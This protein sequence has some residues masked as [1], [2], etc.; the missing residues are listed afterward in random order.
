VF[1]IPLRLHATFLLLPAVV[2]AA[3][4]THGQ[5][6]GAGLAFLALVVACIVFHELGHAVLARRLGIRVSRVTMYPTGGIAW[7]DEVPEPRNEWKIAVAGPAVNLGIALA[8]AV[9]L[10]LGPGPA[11]LSPRASASSDVWGRVTA[12]LWINLFLAAF[13]LVPAYPMDGGRLLRAVLALRWGFGRA[14]TVAAVVGQVLAVGLAAASLVMQNAWLGILAV[15]VFVGAVQQSRAE[16]P[17]E[18]APDRW[19]RESMVTRFETLDPGQLLTEAA[20]KMA[21]TAQQEFPVVDRDGRLR[22]VLTRPSIYH[23]VHFRGPTGTVGDEMDRDV[24]TVGPESDLRAALGD[25]AARADRPILVVNEGRVV[26]MIPAS[27]VREFAEIVVE[28]PAQSP[29]ETLVGER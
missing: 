21:A 28:R 13:N 24:T 7:F 22:G 14:T 3:A 2:A 5:D 18:S 15:V 19:A 12:L 16:R 10:L 8:L 11:G 29:P 26:G 27:Q 25:D 17:R 9:V 4:T 23:G 20:S 6:V 1:G